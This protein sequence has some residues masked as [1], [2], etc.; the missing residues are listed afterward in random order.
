MR[1]VNKWVLDQGVVD[2]VQDKAFCKNSIRKTVFGECL[3]YV[4]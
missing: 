2:A 3:Y 1:L 4:E